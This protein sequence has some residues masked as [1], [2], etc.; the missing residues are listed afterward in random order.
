MR[1]FGLLI[2]L[3][4]FCAGVGKGLYFLKKGFSPRH[5]QTLRKSV[6]DQWDEETERAL[7]QRFHYLAQ[8][9]QCFAFVSEDGKYVLK[10]LRTHIYQLP[11]WARVLPCSATR[12]KILATRAEREDF[13]LNSF[14]IAFETL[15]DE[16]GLLAVHLGQSPS[17]GQ[18]LTLIDALGCK[19][20]LPL[21][22]TPFALQYKHPLLMKAFQ[23]ARQAGNQA[24]AEHI[25][26]AL[27]AA[28]AERGKKGVLNR[29][30]SF[31]RNYGFDGERAYQIDIGSFFCKKELSAQAAFEKSA[32]DSLDAVREWMA[33]NDPA[34]IPYLDQ[35]LTEIFN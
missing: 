25:L 26:S 27:V 31:L 17:R 21:E 7:S 33:A 11:F 8:G 34:M 3:L 32:R 5:V 15:R 9:R 19:H 4:C 1:K 18:T 24:Q 23:K 28:I 20:I 35:K 13:I 22:K 16:T 29:D 2:L 30:R 12:E 10:L 6:A 14:Q